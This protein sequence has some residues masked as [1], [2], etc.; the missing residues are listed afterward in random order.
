MRRYINWPLFAF[1][2]FVT[3]AIAVVGLRGETTRTA[4]TRLQP[5]V[6]KIV[7]AAA[8]CQPPLGTRQ[9]QSCAARIEA[10]LT[11]CRL[12]PSCRQAF[13]DVLSPSKGV[14]VGHGNS[15]PSGLPAPG[16]APGASGGSKPHH[17][18]SPPAPSANTLIPQPPL[19]PTASPHAQPPG[20]LGPALHTVCSLTDRAVH[21]C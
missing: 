14:I 18:G 12:S 3:V 10:G 11:A 4:V 9:L 6:T 5:Q 8:A 7:R 17:A 13:A 2:G 19:P 1:L 21:I 16:P 15:S 20:L